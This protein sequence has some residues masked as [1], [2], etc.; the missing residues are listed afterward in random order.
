MSARVIVVGGGIVGC[1]TAYFAARQGCSVVLVEREQ[2]G[3]G[4]SGRNPGFVWL[5]CRNPGFA[6]EISRA[7]RRLYTHL[8]HELPGGFEFRAEGG[9]IYFNTAAQGTVFEEFVAARRQD[10]LDIE[11]IDG[12]E[13]R[14]MV[15]PIR[16]D[17]LGASFCAEDAQIN[18]P[19]VVRALV[20]GA[21]EHGAHVHEG[22]AAEELLFSGDRVAGVRT[23]DGR[24]E[25]D[26]V[27]L[28]AGAWSNELLG[29]VGLQLP[30][31]AERL[32]VVGT[33]PLPM[34]IEPVVYGPLATKQYTLFRD[35]PSW[36]DE[37]FEAP[38]ERELGIEML[39]LVAQRASG[40]LLMGCPMDY[41]PGVDMRPTLAGLHATA[42][43]IGED[44]PGLV[45][46][47]VSRVWAGALPYTAD[48]L[49]V[50]GEA[51]PGLIVA[52]GHVFGNSAGPMT[53][54]LIAQLIQG[55]EP[56]LDLSEC[57]FDRALAA[58]HG[59]TPSRW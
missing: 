9:L 36:S 7:G 11:L 44:F 54:L 15:P 50:I 2:C 26:A 41:P 13:V 55:L 34:A 20:A 57:R 29:G 1:A 35:L 47:P 27:V 38:Y 37:L 46:A 30:I 39:Q 17:V 3:F 16:A 25:A 53:G 59:D 10:G 52:S 31:G 56:D 18:T 19:Q 22:T 6:L 12:A 5:H 40:E 14:R 28:A 58:V 33:D 4:A 43:A 21:R 42:R 49:P 24:L 45:N 51:R 23:A 8:V 48:M 32:Q